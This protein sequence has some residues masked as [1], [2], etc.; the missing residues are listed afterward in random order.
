MVM[1]DIGK[2]VGFL[3][4]TGLWYSLS[5]MRDIHPFVVVCKMT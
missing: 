5:K 2:C 3:I 1:T 4:N